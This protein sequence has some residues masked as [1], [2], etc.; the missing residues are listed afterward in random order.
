ME[1][2][3]TGDVEEEEEDEEDVVVCACAAWGVRSEEEA[4]LVLDDVSRL[5]DGDDC[6]DS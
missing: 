3:A 6:L 5:F 4:A 2:S 1:G